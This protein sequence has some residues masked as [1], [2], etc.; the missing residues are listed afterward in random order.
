MAPKTNNKRHLGKGAVCSVLGCLLHPTSTVNRMFPNMNKARRFEQMIALSQ[1][2]CHVQGKETM[3][4][5]FQSDDFMED[6]FHYDAWAT[7]RWVRV[8]QPGPEDQRFEK[9]NQPVAMEKTQPLDDQLEVVGRIEPN[10]QQCLDLEYVVKF[11]AD[12][13]VDNNNESAIKNRPAQTTINNNNCTYSE[14]GHNSMRP[15]YK[16][17]QNQQ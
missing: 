9:G 10:L 15:R 7:I 3:C 5:V 11:K 12:V 17:Q 16:F 13:E 2:M 8:D 6:D 4:V 14:W 1:E